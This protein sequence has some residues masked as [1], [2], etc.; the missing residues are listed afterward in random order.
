M[1][2]RTRSFGDPVA[3]RVEFRERKLGVQFDSNAVVAVVSETAKR[4]GVR[5]GDRF[6]KIDGSEVVRPDYLYG[7]D[8][9]AADKRVVIAVQRCHK[10]PFIATFLRK[11]R[12]NTCTTHDRSTSATTKMEQRVHDGDSRADRAISQPLFEYRR[13]VS[14]GGRRGG[15]SSKNANPY[16]RS[17]GGDGDTKICDPRQAVTKMLLA[18]EVLT[19]SAT[20]SSEDET[21]ISP[22]KSAVTLYH[23]DTTKIFSRLSKRRVRHPVVAVA[24]ARDLIVVATAAQ[25]LI[26]WKKP[27]VSSPSETKRANKDEHFGQN[28][29]P[30]PR[31][32]WSRAKEPVRNVFVDPG[33]HHVLVSLM[34]GTCFYV[35]ESSDVMIAIAAKKPIHLNCVVWDRFNGIESDTRQILLGTNDGRVL[36]GRFGRGVVSAKFGRRSSAVEMEDLCCT[37]RVEGEI[38]GLRMVRLVGSSTKRTST[39]YVVLIATVVRSSS[40]TRSVRLYQYVGGYSSLLDGPNFA[41]MFDY[42]KLRNVK[43]CV[44]IPMPPDST[45]AHFGDVAK[46]TCLAFQC[47]L[48]F[49]PLDAVSRYGGALWALSTGMGILSGA[50]RLRESKSGR[51][52]KDDE[53][54]VN[55]PKPGE[56]ATSHHRLVPYSMTKSNCRYP[57]SLHLLERDQVLVLFSDRLELVRLEDGGV[58]RS[59]DLT[60]PTT[61]T[62]TLL[63]RPVTRGG[64]LPVYFERDDAG[65]RDGDGFEDFDTIL[66]HAWLSTEKSI[67]RV[68]VRLFPKVNVGATDDS[69]FMSWRIIFEKLAS[70]SLGENPQ[71]DTLYGKIEKICVDASAMYPRQSW[72]GY[73]AAR[74]CRARLQMKLGNVEAAAT[75][76]GSAPPDV[77]E[78]EAMSKDVVDFEDRV[79]EFCDAIAISKGRET[80][81]MN[82]PTSVVV[83]T[84]RRVVDPLGVTF[85]DDLTVAEV[86]SETERLCGVRVGQRVL[87]VDEEP[88]ATLTQ[89]RA[90][91]KG[92][93]TMSLLVSKSTKLPAPSNRASRALMAYVEHSL[94]ARSKKTRRWRGEATSPE[95]DGDD[96]D[97]E[98]NNNVSVPSTQHTLLATWLLELRLAALDA[99]IGREGS[100]Y[101]RDLRSSE[102][103]SVV[104][105]FWRALD[106]GT[107]IR[108]LSDSFISAAS[109]PASDREEAIGC[110]LE[111]LIVLAE[112]LNERHRVARLLI[113]LRLD[114]HLS[115]W[116]VRMGRETQQRSQRLEALVYRT[117][118][119]LASLNISTAVN[120]WIAILPLLDPVRLLA[121]IMRC[122]GLDRRSTPPRAAKNYVASSVALS[123]GIRFLEYCMNA[124]I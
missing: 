78:G 102:L 5:A 104:A 63:D 31:G 34:D 83:V 55:L 113:S 117:A 107:S 122:V 68:D 1:N 15:D 82:A 44:D 103:A 32:V 91:M 108:A 50:V 106:P 46:K 95:G 114:E 67:Y 73:R 35:H 71:D 123:E 76:F 37:T 112:H 45:P 53:E 52:A 22:S 43:E 14:P 105:E 49:R 87:A 77:F 79:S 51:V 99:A 74:T 56:K 89:L 72:I 57:L 4:A 40:A 98:N 33:G 17:Q 25:T 118:L 58:V 2:D 62:T 60:K 23:A 29:I 69:S 42:Y 97:D 12:S 39:R 36:Q 100:S 116:I 124:Y 9:M 80:S 64:L 16:P 38:W 94:L 10:R 30:I 8:E 41:A 115:K 66:S 109:L 84:R 75:L 93:Y 61:A 28:E 18:R 24:T 90:A 26:R 7:A 119:S 96:D 47:C 6:W 48:S 101:E 59:L 92:R 20:G 81:L 13:H 110:F 85:S 27:V 11:E 19:S 88:V 120:T 70:L 121:A 86:K 65:G 54:D 3:V 21:R 111:P